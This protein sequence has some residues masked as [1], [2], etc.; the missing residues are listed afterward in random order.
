[1]TRFDSLAPFFWV[2]GEGDEPPGKPEHVVGHDGEAHLVI[3]GG[4]VWSLDPSGVLPRR[5]V[6]RSVSQ[7]VDSLAEF[8]EAW[9]VRAD[10]MD[11]AADTQ[12][13]HLR[14]R[15]AHRL[16]CDRRP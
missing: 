6:N 2:T 13:G 7:F 15:E 12:V 16:G 11:A 5:L 9:I 4:E 10:L 14:E 3:A 8:R 1:M